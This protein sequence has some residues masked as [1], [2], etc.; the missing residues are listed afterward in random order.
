MR[1]AAALAQRPTEEPVPACPICGRQAWEHQCDIPDLLGNRRTQFAVYACTGCGLLKTGIPAGGQLYPPDYYTRLPSTPD[2]QRR[3]TRDRLRRLQSFVSS[4]N[5]LDVGCG[6]GNFLDALRAA[7]WHAQGTEVNRDAVAV[8]RKKRHEFRT[9]SLRTQ[10]FPTGFFDAVT[11][12]GTFEHVPEPAQELSEV[13]RILRPGGGLIL[14]VTNAGSREALAFGANWFGY[15]APRHCFNYTEPTVTRLLTLRGFKVLRVSHQAS[16][17]ITA[18][19]IACALHMERWY[20]A[21]S[22]IVSGLV[23]IYRGSFGRLG[24]GNL[25]EVTAQKR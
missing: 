19:S 4:G 18:Y 11:Y 6:S 24:A 13:G 20:P 5:V 7:G 14:N 23:R 22:P 17:L 1:H 8:L 21:I 3:Y 25:L 15:E 9:G 12:I 2:A 16:T 10:H